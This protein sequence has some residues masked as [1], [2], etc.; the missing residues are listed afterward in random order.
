VSDDPELNDKVICATWHTTLDSSDALTAHRID[1][2]RDRE[3]E[4]AAAD[5]PGQ[6]PSSSRCGALS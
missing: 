4:H 3:V 2:Q 1:E 6:R 5:V